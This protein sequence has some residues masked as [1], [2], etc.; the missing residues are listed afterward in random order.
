LPR[1]FG[2]EG[3]IELLERMER[4]MTMG[5]EP[6]SRDCVVAKS[7]E[8]ELAQLRPLLAGGQIATQI[9]KIPRLYG[10]SAFMTSLRFAGTCLVCVLTLVSA[11]CDDS[12]PPDAGPPGDP[13]SLVGVSVDGTVGVLLDDLP[14]SVRDRAAT[15]LVAEPEA[16]WLA[17][18][19]LQLR[20]TGLRLTYRGVFYEESERKQSLPLPP[21]DV[22][23]LEL[24]G[25]PQRRTID[26]HDHVAV[27]YTLRSALLSDFDSPGMSEPAL[28]TVGG[29][30]DEEFVLPV[31]PTLLLQRTG[32]ACM[33][34]DQYPAESVDEQ[35]AGN[36]Y[37]DFCE[38]EPEPGTGC[39]YTEPLPTE[40]CV[41]ALERAI[42]RV[43]L[44]ITYERLPWDATIAESVRSGEITTPDAPDLRVLTSGVESLST[45]RILYRYIPDDHCAVV[46]DCVTGSGW[47]R[48]LAFDS[49]DHNAGGQPLHIGP[50]DY[51]DEG[52]GGELIEHNV[53]VLSECHGHYHF[54]HY[55]DFYL[56]D[57][58]DARIHKNGFCLESTGRLS[59]HELSP[60]WTSYNCHNQGVDPGW[61]DLYAAGLTCNWLDITDLDTSAGPVT[62]ALTFHS[63]PDHFLCEGEL[64]VDGTG[65]Q[66][67]EPTEFRTA[68][69][70]VVDR[71][72]CD[73]TPG[74][75]ANDIGRVDVTVPVIG[76]LMSSPCTEDQ[77]IG[78]MRNCG[79]AREGA[80]IDCTPGSPITLT[81]TA[82][83]AGAPQAVRLCETSRALDTGVDCWFRDAQGTGVVGDTPLTITA[84]C[85]EARDATEIGGQLAVYAAP[86]LAGDARRTITC[87]P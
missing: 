71:P 49:I 83:G 53:Y 69:G 40:S 72:M 7:V 63:N 50:V 23:E 74:T 11:A 79:F 5:S 37:D 16:F 60:L 62:E 33:D 32:Y 76:G 21:E 44:S 43:D 8:S 42:G 46:E 15:E 12:T 19:R 57:R 82:T 73:A 29:T 17:R 66:R 18:A 9:D 22:W 14:A 45:N 36:F 6:H 77:D 52:L 39:H 2:P 51:Y 68:D 70:A 55:G 80:V 34:E 3:R 31:D 54:E 47:R 28:A 85:P 48:L 13:G 58:T 27:D 1:R 81:C 87:V 59:N 26:G 10:L 64:L 35:N 41:E 75:E 65:A 78:A 56:G 86:L 24:A 30:W 38:V 67:W 84:T 25:A 20:L 4:R 61:V